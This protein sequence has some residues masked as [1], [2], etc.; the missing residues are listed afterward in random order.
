MRALRHL[1]EATFARDAVILALVTLVVY[2]LTGDHPPLGSSTRY[3][4]ACREMAE[5]GEWL[6]P[7][8]GYVPYLEKPP[9]TYWLGTISQLLFGPGN[10]AAQAPSGL[11]AFV[12]LLATY[13]IGRLWKGAGFGLTAALLLLGSGMFLGMASTLTTDPILA[14]CLACAW[15]G[16]AAWEH[17]SRQGPGIWGFWIAVGIG[18]LAKGLIAVVLPGC[19]LALYGLLAGGWSGPLRLLR[20]MRPFT[21]LAIAVGISLPWSLWLWFH[22][23]RMLWFF[24]VWIQFQG[25]YSKTVNHSAAWWYYGPILLAMLAPYTLIAVPVLLGE[26]WRTLRDRVGV[27]L[28]WT[29]P[30]PV[31]A[32]LRLRLLFSAIAIAPMV[33]LTLSTSKLGTYPLPLLPAMILLFAGALWN[34]PA[35]SWAVAMLIVKATLLLIVFMAAPLAIAGWHEADEH[36]VRLALG[37]WELTRQDEPDL[38][39]IGWSYLPLALVAVVTLVVA[40]V[41]ATVLAMRRKLVPGLAV[42]AGAF[43]V[44]AALLLPRVDRIVKDLDSTRLISVIRHHGGDR[45]DLPADQRDLVLIHQECVHDYEL[46]RALGRRMIIVGCS[47]ELGFGHFTEIHGPDVPPPKPGQPIAN[48]YDVN[49]DTL[50]QHPWLWNLAPVVKAWNGPRRMW[51]LCEDSFLAQ[52]RERHLTPFVVDK[53]GKNFLLC[54][55]PITGITPW[56]DPEDDALPEATPVAI[57]GS[58]AT[59]PSP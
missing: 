13:G 46:I 34:R 9:L 36:G 59:A 22:D 29:A 35:P 10:L 53:A 7:Q 47:R 56:H 32:D 5:L 24:H 11:A 58:S 42:V 27:A 37:P 50:P 38:N 25:L 51:I 19:A 57:P 15:W 17:R 49:G 39:R 54:D 12:S 23:W 6:V 20:A 44:I 48:P 21:G 8:L 31:D 3:P 30:E 45:A 16:F 4:E 40:L 14:A 33:F 55:R 28:R 43:L 26:W 2:L 1:S 52:L 41:G 18:G